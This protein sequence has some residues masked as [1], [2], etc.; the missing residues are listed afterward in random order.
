MDKVDEDDWTDLPADEQAHLLKYA[1]WEFDYR[2]RLCDAGWISFAAVE[3]LVDQVYAWSNYADK[4]WAAM[5]I[6][7]GE[8]CTKLEDCYQR[9]LK[10]AAMA[11]EAQKIDEGMLGDVDGYGVQKEGTIL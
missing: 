10:R 11:Q 7:V 5:D 9:D 4:G 3:R 1:R 6:V 2:V 8:M